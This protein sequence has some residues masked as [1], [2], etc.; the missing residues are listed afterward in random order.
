MGGSAICAVS[1]AIG[2]AHSSIQTDV[3]K[4]VENIMEEELTCS[5]CSELFISAVRIRRTFAPTLLHL[6]IRFST[7]ERLK[8]EACF[9]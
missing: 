4:R 5:I 1:G 9:T 6:R 2:G 7:I 8:L 3:V